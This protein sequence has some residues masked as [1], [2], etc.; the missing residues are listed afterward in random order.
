MESI[1]SYKFVFRKA[2]LVCSD[3]L[4]PMKKD[5]ELRTSRA[6]LF[7]TGRRDRC[8]SAHSVPKGL[9]HATRKRHGQAVDAVVRLRQ[10]RNTCWR[11][12]VMSESI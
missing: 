3:I 12:F 6:R 5:R 10:S 7:R 1:N 11:V 2:V 4:E 9:D 8:G